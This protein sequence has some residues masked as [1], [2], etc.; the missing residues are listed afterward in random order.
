[1]SDDGGIR[2]RARTQM[3]ALGL[4]AEHVERA[5]YNNAIRR[6]KF[7]ATACSW[8]NVAFT[9][10]YKSSAMSVI[11]NADAIAH[12]LASGIP[13]SDVVIRKP[14]ENRPDVWQDIV[15]RKKERDSAYGAK[16]AANTSMYRCRKCM[17]KECHYFGLQTR[18]GDEPMTIFVS[19]LN[20]GNRWRTEG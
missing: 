10:C 17:S 3:N 4:P 15:D 2:E 20:C 6:C 19:C 1:M 11:R 8:G 9:E 12:A 16:P 14:Q 7:N 5:V 18:S 13:A